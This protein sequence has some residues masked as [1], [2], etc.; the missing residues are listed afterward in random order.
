MKKTLTKRDLITLTDPGEAFSSESDSGVG[1]A[2][3]EEKKPIPCY[4]FGPCGARR[5]LCGV[6]VRRLNVQK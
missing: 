1:S 4:C 5:G 6:A 2:F 3:R